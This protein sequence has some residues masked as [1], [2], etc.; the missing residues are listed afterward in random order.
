M[1]IIGFHRGS[2]EQY[3]ERV[4]TFRDL[5][6]Q[7]LSGQN[8]AVDCRVANGRYEKLP[9]LAAELVQLQVAVIT[10]PFS[11]DA[12]LA[13]K[14]ATNTIPIVFLSSADPVQIG[15]VASLNRPGGNT[16]GVTTLNT[17]LAPKRLELLRE[18]VP[19]PNGY[20]AL[21]NPLSN[22]APGFIRDIEVAA[23]AL[24]IRVEILRASSEREYETGIAG[25][26]RRSVLIC[27]TDALFFV[28]REQIAALAIRYGVAT[29][30]DA[31]AYTKAGGLVSYS[32]DDQGLMLLATGYIARILKGEKP[33]D[34]PVAQ[35]TKF[36]LRT[37]KVS[38]CN[39]LAADEVIR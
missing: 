16:T 37:A 39:L 3:V 4:A 38:T 6:R 27:S 26:P 10:S 29:I 31:P 19:N 15:L 36:V 18:L 24:G 1:P 7:D 32:A 12:A 5:A 13:A 20:F 22:L 30:F 9:G 28:R 2:P 11:T 34:L 35:P 14:A 25:I 21:I 8:V 23:G 17:E 33:A